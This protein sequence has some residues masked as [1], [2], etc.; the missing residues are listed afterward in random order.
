MT[1]AVHAGVRAVSALDAVTF[2]VV[3]GR[4]LDDVAVRVGPEAEYV[5]GLHGLEITGTGGTFRHDALAT[6]QPVIAEM[7]VA[8]ARLLA[9]CPGV[10]LEN[11]MY[12]LT[13]HVR[14]VPEMLQGAALEAFERLARPLVSTHVLRLLHGAYA[15]EL[16]PQVDWDKG[17]AAEWIRGRVE[18]QRRHVMAVYLGDDRT[19]EDAFDALRDEDIVIGVGDRPHAHLID[20]RLAGPAS[21]GRFLARLAELRRPMSR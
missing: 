7:A 17:R 6:V 11:K 3:S 12:A 21:V 9:W 16:L 5:A 18:E 1:E 19:D 13:C 2:G 4:R 14:L 8:A 20:W 15:L 10:H